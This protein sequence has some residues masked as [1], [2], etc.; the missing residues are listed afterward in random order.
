MVKEI[1]LACK[2]N[3]IGISLKNDQLKLNFPDSGIPDDLLL[4]LKENKL[5]IIEFL[6]NKDNKNDR[7]IENL[8]EQDNY[9][10]SASQRRIWMIDQVQGASAEFLMPSLQII[11]SFVDKD[12]FKASIKHLMDRH[13]TLR[14]AFITIEGEIRQKILNT[15]EIPFQYIDLTEF[16]D[17][18]SE[19][20]SLYKAESI[21]GFNLDQCPLFRTILYKL[22]EN[23]FA[24]FYTMHHIVSDGY[25]L[26]NFYKDLLVIYQCLSEN[27]EIK[28]DKLEVQYKDFAAWQNKQI[29]SN[30]KHKDFWL[31]QL[32]G[33]LPVLDLPYDSVLNEVFDKNTGNCY[34]FKINKNLTDSLN[35]LAHNNKASLYMVLLAAFNVLLSKLTGQKDILIGSPVAGREHESLESLIGCF[36][37]TIVLRNKIQDEKT[38][39]DFLESVKNTTVSSLEHQSYPFEELIN[40]LDIKRDIMKYPIASVYFN[41]MNFGAGNKFSTDNFDSYHEK[42]A[43]PVKFDLNCYISELSNATIIS[44]DYKSELF[45]AS[46]IE[47]IF[48]KYEGILEEIVKNPDQQ[49]KNIVLETDFETEEADFNDMD[50]YSREATVVSVFEKQ[51]KKYPEKIAIKSKDKEITYK[52]LNEE[53]NAWASLL[54]ESNEKRAAICVSHSEKVPIGILATLKAAKSYIPVDPSYPKDRVAFILERTEAE[55]VLM[56]HESKALLDSLNSKNK[57]KEINLDDKSQIEKV[58]KENLDIDIDAEDE[59]Y[60]LFTSGSTGEPKGV[61]QNHKAIIHFISQYSSSI[62]ISSEDRLTGFSSNCFDA[63]NNEIYGSLLNGATYL[64]QSLKELSMDKLADWIEEEKPTVW[65]SVPTIFRLFIKE[66]KDRSF[67]SFRIVKMAGEVVRRSDFEGFKELTKKDAKFVVSLGATES[68]FT[69]VNILS[70]SDKMGKAIAP[71]GGLVKRTKLLVLNE[72]NKAQDIL[73]SGE[74][75]I[76]SDYLTRGYFKREDLTKEAFITINGERYYRTGDLGRKLADGKYELLGRKDFQVKI[77]GNRVELAEIESKLLGEEAIKEAVVVIR[78]ENDSSFLAAFLTLKDKQTIEIEAIRSGLKKQL[79][80]YMIPDGFMVLDKMPLTASG[81]ID[82]KSLPKIE[83][84][85]NEENYVAARTETEERLV[86]IWEEVLVREKVGIRDN[87]FELG[88]HSLKAMQVIS[89]VYKVF[90]KEVKLQE[91]FNAETIENCAKVIENKN[92]SLTSKIE[93]VSKRDRYPISSSQRRIWMI[94]QI[95]G[96]SLEYL[97]PSLEYIN[98]EINYELLKKSI[99][100]LMQRH[101]T[102]RTSFDNSNDQLSQ[103]IHENLEIPARFIDLSSNKNPID[104]LSEYYDK[105]LEKGFDLEKAPLFRTMLFKL[106][107]KQYGLLYL[108]HHTISDG[109]SNAL[110]YQELLE[111]YQQITT[112]QNYQADPLAIQYKD[113]ASWQN[114]QLSENKTMKTFWMEKLSG[115]LPVLD[116]P[117]DASVNEV[118]TFKGSCYSFKIEKELAAGLNSLASKNQASI[119]MVLLSAFNVLLSKITGQ[120]DILIGSPVAGREDQSLEKLIGCFINTIVLRTNINESDRFVDFLSSVKNTCLE[121]LENQSYPFEELINDLDIKRDIIKYPVSSV[122]FNMMNFEEKLQIDSTSF[123]N[124]HEEISRPVKFDLNCYIKELDDSIIISCDYKRELFKAETIEAIFGKYLSILN[125]CLIN[126]NEKIANITAELPS[127]NKRLNIIDKNWYSAEETICSVFEK[128]VKQFPDKIAVKSEIDYSYKELNDEVNQWARIVEKS[129]ND[130]IGICVSHN[131]N[132]PL[133]FLSVIKSAKTYV[134]IDPDYPDDRIKSIINATNFDTIILDDRTKD[135][136]KRIDKEINTIDISD[137]RII[138]NIDS[139]NLNKRIQPDANAYILFTSG[140]TGKAKGVVQSHKAVL[141]FVSQY[142]VYLN[143]TENDKLTG[144]FNYAHDSSTSDIYASLFNAATYYPLSLKDR[145]AE[146]IMSLIEKE[147]LTVYHSAPTVFRYLTG[148]SSAKQFMRFKTI[149]MAGEEVRRTD[150][151]LFKSYA[152]DDAQFIVS[153]GSTESTLNMMNRFNKSDIQK[154]STLPVGQLLTRTESLILSESGEVCHSLEKGELFISS[155]FLAKGYFKDEALSSEIFHSKNG[156]RWYKTGDIARQLADSSYELIGRKDSQ[157]KV[158]GNR[159]ELS[160]IESILIQHKIVKE[161]SII[162]KEDSR[163]SSFLACYYT[164]IDE[165]DIDHDELRI[166]LSKNLPD[167]MI[168]EAMMRL[169]E[170][171]LTNSKKIDKRALPEI[172]KVNHDYYV[173]ASTKEEKILVQLFET[174]LNV[175]KIGIKH[176]FFDLGGHSLKAMQL[177]SRVNQSFNTRLTM[178]DIF[179]RPTISDLAAY[180]EKNS[181]GNIPKTEVKESYPI[182]T[183][184]KRYF[185]EL[186]KNKDTINITKLFPIQGRI[187]L[188][189]FESSVQYLLDNNNVFKTNFCLVSD[190]YERFETAE[191]KN[192]YINTEIKREDLEKYIKNLH[193]K[194][195]LIDNGSLIR[196]H[197]IQ[198]I[199]TEESFLVMT[200]SSIVFDLYSIQTIAKNI[201]LLYELENNNIDLLQY[202]DYQNWLMKTKINSLEYQPEQY[203]KTKFTVEEHDKTYDLFLRDGDLLKEQSPNEVQ[204]NLALQFINSIN[205]DEKYKNFSLQSILLTIFISVVYRYSLEKDI[206]VATNLNNRDFFNLPELIGSIDQILPLKVQG[207]S[208]NNTF[209]NM[210]ELISSELNDLKENQFF[211]PEDVFEN[212]NKFTNLYF[213]YYENK[214]EELK[215]EDFKLSTIAKHFN[216][217]NYEFYIQVLNNDDAISFTIKSTISKKSDLEQIAKDIMTCAELI[218]LKPELK[219]DEIELGNKKIT[220]SKKTVIEDDFDF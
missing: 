105:E 120:K 113:F 215:T 58:S 97:M 91:F 33:E 176:S 18:D 216:Q 7:F 56:D 160:E 145:S 156:K 173:P 180:L 127:A 206:T 15:T 219:L 213:E 212:K 123:T 53:V 217:N 140:S 74:L 42:S 108:L 50:W 112:N 96:E 61:V 66:Y 132:I 159:I 111:I 70:H 93:K 129:E 205:K 115:D 19:L 164:T 63:S 35:E 121:A 162:L 67:E 136:F 89:R 8:P 203:W 2:K 167:Y 158:R 25:S 24:V 43:H 130:I 185:T 197:L 186:S 32:T 65:H 38:F 73:E 189:K 209:L 163:D 12:I 168:P 102:L 77:R 116:L 179:E 196:I 174:V 55:L 98:T 101:E 155:D 23:R 13:E 48:K 21:I 199:N 210:L 76:S 144:L 46:T 109:T 133:S 172:S 138:N 177:I 31:K 131:Q 147:S 110:F 59:A 20:K 37:N 41:M 141:H 36:I 52:E 182:S 106:S 211:I 75:V 104:K 44:C 6:K 184:E 134:P 142:S 161:V 195:F 100:I 80:D 9:F 126:P 69:A 57:F 47:A 39:T 198:I 154:R 14:T 153:Y 171:P 71:V 22:D 40:H 178:K 218:L 146:D 166:F 119:Y 84:K 208:D 204:F 94:D 62:E 181:L 139:S 118:D 122:Y 125:F 11:D 193:E 88:G 90:N 135:I 45:K 92:D 49:I 150:F 152:N 16:P 68:T 190:A 200:A 169:D 10:L 87:F 201:V 26:N 103:I 3:N 114:N 202:R 194:E 188:E 107:D 124:H 34:H 191:T 220:E 149:K 183:I 175:E 207:I 30:L 4:K 28:L 165:Q 192:I 143:I 214:I 64:V 157:V 86:K 99:S 79:P 128:Q 51:V 85:S 5:A 82:R 137:K 72:E 78:E 29:T 83:L 1:L 187:D 95:Q 148:N 17:P 60:V 151:D 117:Y 81:K 170:I 54:K 27:R